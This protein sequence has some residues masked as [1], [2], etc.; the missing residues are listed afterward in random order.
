MFHWNIIWTFIHIIM[1]GISLAIFGLSHDLRFKMYLVTN[2]ASPLCQY[3]LLVISMAERH[4]CSPNF[5]TFRSP[6]VYSSFLSLSFPKLCCFL[7]LRY[8]VSLILTV[9]IFMQLLRM[10]CCWCLLYR[11]LFMS[12]LLQQTYS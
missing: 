11:A 12:R 7:F 8:H 5:T 9:A 1:P 6:R 3:T 4:T 10:L 2:L